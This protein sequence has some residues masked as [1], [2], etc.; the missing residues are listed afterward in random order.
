MA[1]QY[2][3]STLRRAVG[4]LLGGFI[5]ILGFQNCNG[6]KVTDSTLLASS[7]TGGPLGNGAGPGDSSS[8]PPAS[9]NQD[10]GN[11]S[12]GS[13]PTPTPTATPPPTSSTPTGDRDLST[14]RALFFGKSRCAN[15]G[16]QLCEDFESGVVSNAWTLSGPGLT[17]D[18]MN[19]ARGMK[20]LHI[21]HPSSGKSAIQE[22]KTFPA[23]NN[24]Y[25]GRIFVY[26]KTLPKN[27]EMNYSH[28][29]LIAAN[30]QSATPGEIRLGGELEQGRNSFAVGTDSRTGTGDWGFNDSDKPFRPVPINE[31]MCLE[32]MHK[33]D[34]NETRF[35]WDGVE[36]K[37]MYTSAK[38]HGG[39]QDKDFILPNFDRL[40]IGWTSYSSSPQTFE[41]WIDEIAIDPKR[42][43]C[44]Q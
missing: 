3:R 25:Y 8:P 26:F 32:W 27:P 42:I 19:A 16:L 33:G 15:S 24:T 12:S 20:A 10:P 1:Y 37:S 5:L 11:N 14:D 34:T 2:H 35:W 7:Q 29:T 43:G 17:V 31:W 30:G 18:S 36:H 21:V 38:K 23:P 4:A 41:L 6:F 13:T 40:W 44:V 39:Y 28:W 22:T 9:S